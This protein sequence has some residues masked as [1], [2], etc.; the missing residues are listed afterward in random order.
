MAFNWTHDW[1]SL[2]GKFRYPDDDMTEFDSIMRDIGVDEEILEAGMW[3][4]VNRPEF[5]DEY[6]NHIEELMQ[7]LEARA[8]VNEDVNIVRVTEEE[9]KA[10]FSKVARNVSGNK[11]VDMGLGS[12]TKY[13]AWSRD[14]DQFDW[15]KVEER[16][17]NI[18]ENAKQNSADFCDMIELTSFM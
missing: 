13:V 16:L 5:F 15:E 14:W 17:Q 11:Y 7:E 9:A 2:I 3:L 12:P 18:P 6:M 8:E 1:E 10:I 4:S